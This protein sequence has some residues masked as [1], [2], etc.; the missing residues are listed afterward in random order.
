MAGS[1][2]DAQNA[3]ARGPC[4]RAHQGKQVWPLDD[5]GMRT[6]TTLAS[7]IGCLSKWAHEY[8][9][10][11]LALSVAGLNIEGSHG[12]ATYGLRLPKPAKWAGC[13]V[14]LTGT[15]AAPMKTHG[16]SLL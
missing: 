10:S 3:I 1:G 16:Q 5:L 8:E 7:D 9:C 13:W 2:G 6:I 14:P 15:P 12:E 4:S 11:V